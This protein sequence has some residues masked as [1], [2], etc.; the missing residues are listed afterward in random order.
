MVQNNAS[1]SN[2]GQ[3][4]DECELCFLVSKSFQGNGSGTKYIWKRAIFCILAMS[5]NL[6]CADPEN[7]VRGGPTL[8]TYLFFL[9]LMRGEMIQI[10]LKAGHHQP[11]SET[12]FKW[13]FAGGPMMVHIEC[14][15]GSFVIFQRIWS[16]IAKKTLSFCEG[17]WTPPSGSAHALFCCL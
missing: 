2:N 13:R 15:P 4:L 7:F 1:I 16:S 3:V 12:P 10:P 17:V 6:A 9:K 11:A 8:T 14:W 5:L